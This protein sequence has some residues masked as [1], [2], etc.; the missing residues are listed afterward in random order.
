MSDSWGMCGYYVSCS[1]SGSASISTFSRVY[2]NKWKRAIKH[3]N[4]D[5]CRCSICAKY[6][7]QRGL[8][9]TP[10]AK[11]LTDEAH[12]QHVKS[13]FCDRAE[14]ARLQR[15]SHEASTPSPHPVLYA[16]EDTLLTITIDG[17]DQALAWSETR[18]G[19]T[20][21]CLRKPSS[22]PSPPLPLIVLPLVQ[23]PGQHQEGR[24]RKRNNDN[25]EARAG[26]GDETGG[27]EGRG[28]G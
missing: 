21:W 8:V 23:G 2:R 18:G 27:A 28:R 15:L 7:K 5:K 20:I 24:R 25:W 16:S 19:G 22:T 11:A 9:Q 10:E 14:Y 4:H 6:T 17:M 26:M 12:A 3:R 13:V 1:P